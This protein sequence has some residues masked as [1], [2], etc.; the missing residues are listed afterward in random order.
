MRVML[1]TNIIISAALFP[2]GL[3]AKALFK[4]LS[5]PYTPVIC[6]YV[7][8]ELQRKFEEKFPSKMAELRAFLLLI[9]LKS[10]QLLL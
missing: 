2:D 6:D 4:T 3:T 10:Y 7:I 5:P 8:E 1:D 9:Q